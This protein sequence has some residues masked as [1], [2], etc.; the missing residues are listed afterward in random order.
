MARSRARVGHALRRAIWAR[1]SRGV[2][3]AGME[4]SQ[5]RLLARHSRGVP[6]AARLRDRRGATRPADGPGRWSGHRR[7]R[8]SF[9]ARLSRARPARHQLRHRP[10]RHAARLRVL[11]CEG[12]ALVRGRSRADGNCRSARHDRRGLSRHHLTS[13]AQAAADRDRRIRSRR[14]RGV[15][16]PAA[17][18]PQHD[19]VLELHRRQHGAPARS[20][21]QARRQ[22]RGRA[23]LG[24]RVREPAVLRGLPGTR[25]QRHR[26]AG[27]ER[28]PGLRQDGRRPDF[29]HE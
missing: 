21:R 17:R 6:Q 10:H 26:A 24:V 5:H 20:C 29:G 16:G 22:P 18:V 11:P 25:Q 15:P 7:A 27:A 1:G 3:L 4:R 14:V 28:V 13:R 8:R 23:D 12:P 2:V 19:H 9:H